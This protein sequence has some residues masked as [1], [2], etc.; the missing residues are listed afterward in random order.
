MSHLELTVLGGGNMGRALIGGLL[1]HG[2][3]PEQIAVGESQEA[4]RTSLSR[5]FGIAATPD[6]AVAVAKANVIVLAVKP[7]QVGPV[8]TSLATQLRQRRPVVLSVAAGVRIEVLQSWC[9]AGVPVIRAMPNRPA[10]VGAGATGLFASSEVSTL[11]RAMAEQ[12]MQSV[13]EV[14][15]VESEDALDAVT[16]VSGSGPAYFFLLAEAMAKAGVDLGLPLDT[17]RRLSVA[18]LHGAG[19]M[20]QVG[21]GDLA[22]LRAEVTSKGGTTE[23]A[24]RVLQDA[25]FNE[26]VGRALQAAAH[27]SRELAEEAKS[28]S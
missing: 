28:T 4:A 1:R 11:H 25:G 23:A 12:V 13:G 18:T 9:G 8:L 27:R 6:N 15:W 21:D 19:L 5:E 2:M 10:L 22:R 3:R 24:V 16:A 7:Y 26:L 20:A 14:V 17:A